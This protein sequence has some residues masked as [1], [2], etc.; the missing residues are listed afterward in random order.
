MKRWFMSFR[1]NPHPIAKWQTIF[2]QYYEDLNMSGYTFGGT[3][4]V[5]ATTDSA[6]Y[7]LGG[8]YT[9]AGMNLVDPSI[10]DTI[11][12]NDPITLKPG[13]Y[14]VSIRVDARSASYKLDY[15]LNGGT[16]WMNLETKIKETDKPLWHSLKGHINLLSQSNISL[17][18]QIRAEN[19]V[20]ITVPYFDNCLFHITGVCSP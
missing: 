18:L 4:S 5:G 17:R 9:I 3:L 12:R 13:I 8:Y 10:W 7:T 2:D 19:L 1:K 14:T 16:T 11:T 20:G 6:Y 15:S